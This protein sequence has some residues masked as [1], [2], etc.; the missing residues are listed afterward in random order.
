M[1][2][3]KVGISENFMGGLCFVLALVGGYVPILLLAGYI[4]LK[5]NSVILK[6]YVLNALAMLICFSL[7]VSVVGILPDIINFVDNFVGLFNGNCTAPIIDSIYYIVLYA[8]EIMKAVMFLIYA[9]M[10]IKGKD[11]SMPI[12][13]K[14][15]D[16]HL[17]QEENE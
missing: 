7:I 8:V 6:K 12:V 17:E 14:M 5:E 15:I 13:G 1:S 16:K 2:K 4:L 9:V 10:A 11:S 3:T